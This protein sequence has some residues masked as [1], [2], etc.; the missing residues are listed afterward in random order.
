MKKLL[1]PYFLCI[2]YITFGQVIDS[3]MCDS[4]D[5]F[6]ITQNISLLKSKTPLTIDSILILNFRNAFTKAP[7]KPVLVL[8][9]DPYYYWFR[10]I[11]KNDQPYAKPLMLLMA[12]IGM[13]DG[14]LYQ[15]NNSNWKLIGETGIKYR[16][17]E[18]PYQYTHF[19]FPL[20]IQALTVDT[21]FLS[22]DATDVYKSYGFALIKPKALK[23]F[24]NKLYFLFGIIIGLLILFCIFN[25]YLFFALKEQI[26]LWYATYIG[27][28]FLVVMKNDHLDQQFL[29]WDSEFAYRLTPLMGV[30]AVAL[31]LL[32]HVVQL[33]LININKKSILYKISF[34]AKI[35][36]FAS[37]FVFFIC[38]YIR[39]DYRV[40]SA[41]FYWAEYSTLLAT[42]IIMI[43]C[44]YS[45]ANGFKS[46]WFILAGLFVFLIGVVQ[47]LIFPSTLSFLFP[48]STFHVGIIL[49][50]LIIS[51]GLIYQYRLAKQSRELYIKETADLKNSFDKSLL[52]SKSEIQE[53]TFKTISQEIHDNI[54]Q[55]LTLV[56]LNL[57]TIDTEKSGQSNEKLNN[58]KEILGQV[59]QDLR[60][61][62]KTLNSDTITKIGIVQAIKMELRGIEKA[63][64]IKTI[65]ECNLN[66]LTLDPHVELILFRIMQ[67]SLHNIIKH[68]KA[69]LIKVCMECS[70]HSLQL[71]ISDNGIGFDKE[72]Y[73]SGSG[74][75][76]IGSRC[77][78]IN[79]AFEIQ[80]SKGKGTEVSISL[81][82]PY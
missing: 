75:S 46:A 60:D 68:A 1:L 7:N 38:F 70:D 78:L 25:L 41:V 28:L 50:T 34:A 61:L 20:T 77:K 14:K 54:G 71:F 19:V 37:G 59:I 8:D 56:K 30:G 6:P 15:K 2:S 21:L 81:P 18:R 42:V 3:R 55:M 48:P 67:E 27:F 26:H 17:E 66:P 31:S 49:E 64:S 36:S 9:Y 13:N 44:I 62:S 29:H 82:I 76:N 73:T 47:R 10:I 4:T 45:I 53:Q 52:Q 23:I 80:S 43:D 16:F 22:T 57:N 69:S 74:L 79:A 24:E 40:L 32:V 65:F 51:F 39:A 33:F 72:I 35:N 63:V 11:I 5:R 12:P 58:A